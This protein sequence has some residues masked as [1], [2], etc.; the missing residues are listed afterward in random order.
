[1]AR[2]RYGRREPRRRIARALVQQVPDAR[3]IAILIPN[4]L[5]RS[6][7]QAGFLLLRSGVTAAKSADGTGVTSVRALVDL[8][9]PNRFHRDPLNS[10]SISPG[11]SLLEVAQQ[12]Q[13]EFSVETV[14]NKFYEEYQ[15]VRN[16]VAAALLTDNTRHAAL[17]DGVLD[18]EGARTWATRMMGRLLFLWFLQSKGWLGKPGGHGDQDYWWRGTKTRSPCPGSWKSAWSINWSRSVCATRPSAPAPFCWA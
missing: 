10:L 7:Q 17:R 2:Q 13:R 4:T 11:A 18:D 8:A 12:W 14:T 3:A 5:R 9:S 6:V 15:Q 1:M 16:K